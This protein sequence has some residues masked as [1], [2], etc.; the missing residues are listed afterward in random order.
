MISQSHIKRRLNKDLIRV[1][2]L[3]TLYDI[4]VKM[5]YTKL[6]NKIR[7]RLNYF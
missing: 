4:C 3:N 7:F 5:G 1:N 2:E 6:L